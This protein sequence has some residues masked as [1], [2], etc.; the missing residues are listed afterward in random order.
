MQLQLGLP[1]IG[2]DKQVYFIDLI[3]EFYDALDVIEA[4]TYGPLAEGRETS[5]IRGPIDEAI[6][7]LSH[8]DR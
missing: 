6:A 4:I 2:E 1:N 3:P 7:R 8:A 5:A